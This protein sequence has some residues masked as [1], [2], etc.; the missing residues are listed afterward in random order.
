MPDK[1]FFDSNVVLYLLSGD[2]AK[3]SAV[4]ALLRRYSGRRK[5]TISVQVLNEVTQVTQRKLAYTWGQTHAVIA[6]LQA[7]CEVVPLTLASH[8]LG[9]KL[10]ER[11]GFSVYDAMIVAA[12]SLSDARV[13]YSEDLQHGL[14]VDAQLT[15]INPFVG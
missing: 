7:M 8:T 3:L 5:G 2:A 9:R 6:V 10:A 1:V 12:A 13:L 11:Y 14:V 4:Q 15:V